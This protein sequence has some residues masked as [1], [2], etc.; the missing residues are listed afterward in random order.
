M[1]VGGTL[2]GDARRRRAGGLRRGLVSVLTLVAVLYAVQLVNAAL[3]QRLC[4]LGVRPRSL[5]GLPGIALHPFLHASFGHLLANT[6]PLVVL[7]GLIAVRGRR[8]FVELCV[9]VVLLEGV[10]VWLLGG[11]GTVQVGVSGLVFG[12][13]GYLVARG[14]Y[15]RKFA[16]VA[17]G[18]LVIL[19]YGGAIWGV[20][21]GRPGISW[22]GHLFGLVAG[23][24]AARIEFVPSSR[25]RPRR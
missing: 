14:W 15:E 7:G 16:S 6:L 13:F 22:Y 10:G 23:G 8:E 11:A 24:L 4:G 25:A 21:P 2:W 3:G 12:C 19:L 5:F 20:L 9:W 18:L 1:G 17:V